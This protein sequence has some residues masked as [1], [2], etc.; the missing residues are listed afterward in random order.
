MKHVNALKFMYT[1]I[2]ADERCIKEI[3]CRIVQAKAEFH[4]IK[5]ILFNISLSIKARERVVRSYIGPILI[6][7]S[8]SWAQNI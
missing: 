6:Y 2:A 7:E 4:K 8:V 5:N 1:L 3:K